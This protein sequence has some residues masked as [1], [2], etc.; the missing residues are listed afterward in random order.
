MNAERRK[1][2]RRDVCCIEDEG[3]EIKNDR[4]E[5]ED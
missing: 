2:D 1:S 4:K 3:G 5:G